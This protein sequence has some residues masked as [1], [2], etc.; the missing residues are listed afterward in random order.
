VGS[1]EPSASA[2]IDVKSFEPY[3]VQLKR[4]LLADI[5]AERVEGDLLPSEAQ[6]CQRYGVSRTVVRQALAELENERLVLKVK[7]NGTFVTGRKLET[8]FIQ[9]S[10]GFYESMRAAG[11]DVKSTVLAFRTEPC[12]VEVARQL[13]L[14]VGS[15]I[16]RLDRVRSVD[17]RPVQVVRTSS[18]SR[19][20]PG[21]TSI[22]M[23][24][25]SFYQVIRDTYG[26]VPAGG[27]R[28]IE[29]TEL[30]S[31]EAARLGAPKGIPALRLE[32]VTREP[33]GILFEHYVAIY[34][35][36]SFKFELEVFAAAD[37]R[38]LAHEAGR[39]RHR[40]PRATTKKRDSSRT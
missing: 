40:G 3:Y 9:H 17:G 16:V 19:L 36:D 27:R 22:D 31:D 15:E 38:H 11:H 10:F 34:R 30:S 25:R 1:G 14:A 39:S 5:E 35:G 12:G 21:I 24:D 18:P 28:T 33:Q 37:D 26:I 32:S 4:I 7:G 13:E 29:A 23:T 8:G 20:L 6:L 2:F